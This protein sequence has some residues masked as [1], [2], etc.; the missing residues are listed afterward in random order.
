MS[1]TTAPTL[2]GR[3]DRSHER[4]T[5][6]RVIRSEWTKLWTLR[7]TRWSLA[8]A[9]LAQAGLGPL[10]A[11][12]EMARWS[13]LTLQDRLT[14]NPIDHSLG[15]WHLAQLAVAIL[16]VMTIT[17]EYH[18]GMIRSSM[19]AAPKRLPVLWAKLIVFSVVVLVLMLVAAFIGFLGGQAIFTQHHVNVAL[20]APRALRTI[21]G[22]ALFT[23]VTGALCIAL[24]TIVRRTAGGIA[25]FVGVFFVLPGLIE[26]LPSTTANAI[27]PYLP[28]NAGGTIAQ[29]L[30]DP[31]T[32]SAWGGF[33]LFCGYTVAVIAIAAVL[34]LRRDA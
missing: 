4:V 30:A 19:M 33:A 6:P 29:A 28:N 15:G 32:F 14:I 27:H 5:L 16:G 25:L 7:S 17:G 11:L 13:H 24:G 2:P 23:T 20:S 12:I 9:F 18:T 22:A 21:F 8:L 10:I 3:A 31:F 34:L 1:A 26:I